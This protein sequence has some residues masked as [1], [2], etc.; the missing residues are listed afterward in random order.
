M[1]AS[2]QEEQSSSKTGASAVSSS[3][4]G[5]L[6]AYFTHHQD[7]M[8]ATFIRISDDKLQTALTVLVVAIALSLP[9][10]LIVGLKNVQSLGERWDTEPKL[11]IYINAR[12]KQQA[13]DGLLTDLQSDASV[14]NARFISSEQALL[15]FETFAGFGDALAGLASNPLPPAIEITLTNALQSPQAQA[16]FASN[17]QNLPIVDEAS[18]DLEWVQRFLSI[19][20]LI[21]KVV[22]VIASM[23]AF[24]TILVIGN[25][26]RLIIENRKDEI[27]VTKLVGGTD[28][29]V[30]RPLIYTGAIYGLLG[31]TL[32]VIF[33]WLALALSSGAIQRVAES[34]GAE[35]DLYRLGALQTLQ[36]LGVGTVIGW[37]GAM[38]ASNRH[39][40]QIE[41][42]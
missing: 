29:F 10:L 11:T 40:R 39:L 27:I 18:I 12:A 9:A 35:F 34:Y 42:S 21:S 15:E 13:I 22:W 4:S 23:L 36:I 41:P 38:L 19:T 26:V 33:V 16:E 24:G 30:Q 7:A 37:L 31:A 14:L 20:E 8:R 6:R 28:A 32:A 17:M 1:R 25:T 2:E 3:I 5:R